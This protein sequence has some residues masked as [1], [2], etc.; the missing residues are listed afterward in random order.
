MAF[1]KKSKT[2]AAPVKPSVTAP[3]AAPTPIARSA[4]KGSGPTAPAKTVAA[5]STPISHEQIAE[6]AHQIYLKRG[7]GPGDAT[8]DWIEAERQ[9]KAGR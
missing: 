9:L 2:P 8:S 7:F 4:A 6:R 5:I 3:A 1:Q